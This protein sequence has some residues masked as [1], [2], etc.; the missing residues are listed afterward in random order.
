LRVQGRVRNVRHTSAASLR[1]P[2]HLFPDL[3]C[4]GAKHRE[5]VKLFATR[6]STAHGRGYR[7]YDVGVRD[8]C[9]VQQN[10]CDPVQRESVGAR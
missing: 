10:T 4:L 1:L 2:F 9:P 3:S 5:P 6:H 8:G 7:A